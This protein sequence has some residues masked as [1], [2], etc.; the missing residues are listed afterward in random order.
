MYGG[1]QEHGI[2]PGTTPVAL[3]AGMG[4]ASELALMHYKE[5]HEHCAEIKKVIIDEL[6][7]SGVRFGFNGDQNYC[8][9]NTV[10]LQ[11]EGVSSEALMIA[12]KQYCGISNGSACTSKDYSPSYVLKAMGLTDTEAFN[13]V[14]ISWGADTDLNETVLNFRN[15]LETVKEFQL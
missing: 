8:V 9:S 15:L 10:N 2:R 14:R 5:N 1:Q 13:S 11:F 4:K 7:N 6:H 3:A 12:T